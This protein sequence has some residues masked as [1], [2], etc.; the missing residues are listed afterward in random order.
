MEKITLVGDNLEIVE[1]MGTKIWE[2]KFDERKKKVVYDFGGK[3]TF[4]I[5][6]GVGQFYAYDLEKSLSDSPEE[7][8][9]EYRKMIKSKS[10]SEIQDFF[11]KYH[12][13]ITGVVHI[14]LTEII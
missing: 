1:K 5:S 2:K 13:E 7:I 12:E 11:E 6:I 10:L 3:I 8:K 4:C 14:D 9:M